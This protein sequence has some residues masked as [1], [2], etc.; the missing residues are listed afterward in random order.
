MSNK[1][2]PENSRL[3]SLLNIYSENRLANDYELVMRELTE[4]NSCLLLPSKNEGQIN[5]NWR[6]TDENTPLLKLSCIY[7][8]DGIKTLGVFTDEDSLL[9]WA[10][11][12]S[13]YVAMKSKD[14]LKLC[15]DND[16]YYMVINS[17]L[18]NMF[19]AQRHKN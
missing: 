3:I 19:V 1:E 9:E 4:G 12:K 14:V 18:P 7:E 5:Y 13:T 2:Y 15:E 6:V 8:V 17:S 16:I 11:V 10:K